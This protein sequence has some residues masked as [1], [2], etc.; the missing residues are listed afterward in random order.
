MDTSPQIEPASTARLLRCLGLAID[1]TKLIKSINESKKM[2]AQL[3]TH[4][5]SSH[6][7]LFL[8]KEISNLEARLTKIRRKASRMKIVIHLD[9]F[10]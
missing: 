4:D 7:L 3:E 8:K 6:R 9:K 1:E 10:K 2:F 5:P